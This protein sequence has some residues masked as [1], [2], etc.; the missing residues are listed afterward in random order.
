MLSYFRYLLWE[1]CWYFLQTHLRVEIKKIFIANVFIKGAMKER[2]IMSYH[3]K[4]TKPRKML[5][6]LVQSA[7]ANSCK[8]PW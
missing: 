3:G 2:N 7:S 1:K 4:G 5:T 8:A 6:R